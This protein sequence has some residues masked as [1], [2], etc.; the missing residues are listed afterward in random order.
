MRHLGP[1]GFAS[2]FQPHACF[3]SGPEPLSMQ[4][5]RHVEQAHELMMEY[6]YSML[7]ISAAFKH[8]LHAKATD[9]IF[10]NHVLSSLHSR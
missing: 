5:P 2:R 1:N 4:V 10:A 3:S 6:T 8:G 7:Y 9:L